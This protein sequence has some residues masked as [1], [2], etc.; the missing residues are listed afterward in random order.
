MT[1]STWSLPVAGGAL[2]G[3]TNDGTGT[4]VLFVHTAGLSAMTWA[5]VI[6]HLPDLHC[7]AMD[8][9]GHSLSADAPVEDATRNWRDVLRVSEGLGLRRPVV[10]GGN[11]GAFM[12]LGAAVHE[13][14]AFSALVG[15]E[16]A[17]PHDSREEVYAQLELAYSDEFM[18]DLGARFGFGEVVPS[19]DDVE[20]AAA[21]R[22]EQIGADW[23]L[24][25]VDVGIGDETRYSFVRRGEGWLHTPELETLRTLYTIDLDAHVFP[26][27]G[28]YDLVDIPL[29]LV[30]AAG[31]M[32]Q[33]SPEEIDSLTTRRP[34]VRVHEIGGSHLAHRSHAGDLAAII[35]EV[36][37]QVGQTPD[38]PDAPA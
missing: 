9:R 12:A 32:L 25:D 5:P 3:L 31:G 35:R 37:A 30:Q 19:L 6:S 33:L 21:E 28:A 13:P 7:V 2:G 1:L 16:A 15:I 36:V 29:H 18:A 4:D 23:L 11:S 26:H 8:L 20:T 10:V 22:V 27:A 38:R 14:Q 24:A 17:L 34:S